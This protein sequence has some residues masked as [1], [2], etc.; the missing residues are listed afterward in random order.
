M[1]NRTRRFVT[2]CVA[3][4]VVV[5]AHALAAGPDSGLVGPPAPGVA[6]RERTQRLGT[7]TPSP[8][9]QARKGAPDPGDSPTS[10]S[11]VASMA[12]PLAMVLGLIVLGAAV[13]RRVVGQRTALATAMGARAPAPA[14]LVEV[15]GRYPVSRGAALVLLKLDQ[16]VLLLSHAAP[17]RQHPGG[18]STLAEVSEPEEVASILMKVEQAQGESIRQ[19]FAHALEQAEDQVEAAAS[20]AQHGRRVH[21]V[22]A[23]DRVELWDDRGAIEPPPARRAGDELFPDPVASLKQRL[24]AMRGSARG[25][26]A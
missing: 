21:A 13:L 22:P 3:C 19:K 6:D 5:A 8:A 4:T 25:D 11:S 15:L 1:A 24:A 14:G 7:P 9:E 10:V 12:L 26:A 2:I 23:G 18:F 17:T 16:R 20:R